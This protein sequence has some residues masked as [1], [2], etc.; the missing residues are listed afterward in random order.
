M[1]ESADPKIESAK[2]RASYNTIGGINGPLVVLDGV[3]TPETARH[4]DLTNGVYCGIGEIPSVQ[5]DCH[6]DTARWLG[7]L[8]S[9][10]G[11]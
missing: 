4:G 6:S 8:R 1:S 11:G 9:S 7:A 5:R 2:P 10:V 3:R